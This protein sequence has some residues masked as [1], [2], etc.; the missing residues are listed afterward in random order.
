MG[1]V[2]GNPIA[3]LGFGG[4]GQASVTPPSAG[5]CVN[6]L[7]RPAIAMGWK[8][9]AFIAVDLLRQ[10]ALWTHAYAQTHDKMIVISAEQMSRITGPVDATSIL[11]LK[12]R[13][14]TNKRKKK[15]LTTLSGCHYLVGRSLASKPARPSYLSFATNRSLNLCKASTA[16]LVSASISS[17]Q[18]KS[19]N[20]QWR[21]LAHSLRLL[22]IP[23]NNSNSLLSTLNRLARGTRNPLGGVLQR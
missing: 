1:P 13:S 12:A 11:S 14:D 21:R 17:P 5:R 8:Q 19:N 18:A 6:H 9:V 16:P 15:Q 23:R 4:F 7:L 22:L 3:F 20:D 2:S 10:N